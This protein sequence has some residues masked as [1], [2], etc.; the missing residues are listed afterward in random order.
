M[1]EEPEVESLCRLEVDFFGLLV[2]APSPLALTEMRAKQLASHQQQATRATL[3]SGVHRA[4]ELK[5]LVATLDVRAIQLGVRVSPSVV[6]AIRD[7]YREDDLTIIQEIPYR[8]IPA[9]GGRFLKENQ[10]SEYL[11][12]GANFILLDKLEKTG[13]D[14]HGE[15]P[16][17][18]SDLTQFRDRHPGIPLLLAASVTCENVTTLIDASG[19]AGIDVCSSVRR[20]GSICQEQVAELM[21]QMAKELM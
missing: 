4:E 3:V 8:Q 13:R 7:C 17:A 18:T 19:A 5:R 16:I 12:A 6:R 14:P 9:G 15:G 10:V 11:D 20:D 2:E 21:Q 1:R